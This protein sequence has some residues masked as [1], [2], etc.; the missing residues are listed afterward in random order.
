MGS[1]G[2]PMLVGGGRAFGP[3]PKGPDGWLRKVNRKEEQLGLRVALSE[4]WRTGRL[5]VVQRLELEEGPSTRVLKE[6]LAGRQWLDTLFVGSALSPAPSF[7]LA[8]GNLPDVAYLN[9]VKDLNVWEV[10]KRQ[11]VVIELEAV[12]QVISRIDPDGGWELAQSLEEELEFAEQEE[13]AEFDAVAA[14]AELEAELAEAEAE[15]A[16]S[17]RQ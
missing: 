16:Q 9:D 6:K 1:K 14:E 15:I 8:C 5:S 7:E 3:R 13:E 11:N 10:V 12:D 17:A 2:S 4:K